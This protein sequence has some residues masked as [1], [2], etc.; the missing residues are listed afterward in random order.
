MV[1]ITGAGTWYSLVALVGKVE[2]RREKEGTMV[3]ER[4]AKTRSQILN[5]K[6]WVF[7]EGN[8]SRGS[9]LRT[10]NVRNI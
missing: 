7:H 1:W 10:W 6:S 8:G 3:T 9:L 4:P 5:L 2:Q